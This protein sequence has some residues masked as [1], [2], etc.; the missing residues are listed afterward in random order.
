VQNNG[1]AILI[2]ARHNAANFHGRHSLKIQER[3]WQWLTADGPIL[4]S[5]RR[6]KV[7]NCETLWGKAESEAQ[8]N[9]NVNF[10]FDYRNCIY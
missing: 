9:K 1:L 4:P 5:R 10:M 3:G 2:M 7:E 6:A 8:L